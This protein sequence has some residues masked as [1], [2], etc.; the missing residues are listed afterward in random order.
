MHLPYGQVTP[1]YFIPSN[2]KTWNWYIISGGEAT[3]A[4]V[5]DAA[6]SLFQVLLGERHV[7]RAM[8]SKLVTTFGTIHPGLVNKALG[9]NMQLYA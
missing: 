7:T 6:V 4:L 1:V 5:D 8:N 2:M 9:V 3:E